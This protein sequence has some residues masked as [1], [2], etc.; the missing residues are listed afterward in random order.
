MPHDPDTWARS[1]AGAMALFLHDPV[2]AA[3]LAEMVEWGLELQAE[4]GSR[5]APEVAIE[6]WTRVGDKPQVLH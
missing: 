5:P 3:G 4:H 6:I 1:F 2:D